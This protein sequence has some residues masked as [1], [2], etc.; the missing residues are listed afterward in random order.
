MKTIV[1]QLPRAVTDWLQMKAQELAKK[2]GE[3]CEEWVDWDYFDK[4]H[5]DLKDD[6]LA[7][8]HELMVKISCDYSKCSI[9]CY[10]INI[11]N[12]KTCNCKFPKTEV[13]FLKDFKKSMC[14]EIE[15]AEEVI[16][17]LDRSE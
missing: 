5:P 10:P 9:H 6:Y 2:F 16:K 12:L 11:T 8:K 14:L 3:E 15:P 13:A 17:L 1:A 4:L 7:T